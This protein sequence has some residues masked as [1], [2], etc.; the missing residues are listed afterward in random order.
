MEI[1]NFKIIRYLYKDDTSLSYLKEFLLKDINTF[2]VLEKY[3][4]LSY[5]PDVKKF[6]FLVRHREIFNKKYHNNLEKFE[7]H[8]LSIFK[9]LFT[10]DIFPEQ[11][12]VFEYRILNEDNLIIFI[13]IFFLTEIYSVLYRI[14]KASGLFPYL[15]EINSLS[16]SFLSL[17]E[18]DRDLL[19]IAPFIFDNL[20]L[21]YFYSIYYSLNFEELKSEGLYHFYANDQLKILKAELIDKV[22][23][24]HF[25][26]YSFLYA[27]Y[28]AKKIIHKINK[29][30]NK[31]TLF[32]ISQFNS[33]LNIPKKIFDVNF[34]FDGQRE[35]HLIT[36]SFPGLDFDEKYDFLNFSFSENFHHQF[37][38]NIDKI[39][40]EEKIEELLKINNDNK[41]KS[42][43]KINLDKKILIEIIKEF[44]D[45]DGLGNHEEDIKQQLK[46]DFEKLIYF[47]SAPHLNE[48]P[49]IRN[50]NKDQ[51]YEILVFFNKFLKK[52]KYVIF[53]NNELIQLLLICTNNL[54]ED[55]NSYL[56][57]VHLRKEL[58]L[59]K[60]RVRVLK[61]KV[62]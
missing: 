28:S 1:E 49:N 25:R 59:S 11:A 61:S 48:L 50:I 15:M 38:I 4:D 58:N 30:E 52:E 6:F 18:L 19:L 7:N 22:G 60:D 8:K 45:F 36:G 44:V 23:E 5:E 12:N 3:D 39:S 57:K 26:N 46:D 54:K 40:K 37:A 29:T 27:K 41:Y 10:L 24:S 55:K 43:L 33:Q 20:S 9:F 14:V 62:P 56:K 34:I 32:F 16:G 53:K 2:K 31:D 47:C 13:D 21:Q 35:F 17:K 42:F 51:L